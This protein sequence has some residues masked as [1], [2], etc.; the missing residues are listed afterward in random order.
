VE[1]RA[2]P[3]GRVE[4]HNGHTVR[5]KV[6]GHLGEKAHRELVAHGAAV[7]ERDTRLGLGMRHIRRLRDDP[8]EPVVRDRLEEV[9]QAHLEPQ[10]VESRVEARERRR[11]L[12][13]VRADGPR[14]AERGAE[15]RE[16]PRAGA[17]VE[18]APA[19]LRR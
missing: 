9:T 3:D 15:Q 12:V 16:R 6:R 2:A 18:E 11:A 10:V 5:A 8:V 14:G 4:Q 17:D 1:R 7:Q 19:K 13:Y